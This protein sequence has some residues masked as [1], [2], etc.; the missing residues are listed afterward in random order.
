M[1]RSQKNADTRAAAYLAIVCV[2]VATLEL[3][4]L[5]TLWPLENRLADAFIRLQA[6]SLQPDPDI[7]VVDIDDT[8]LAQME[9]EVGRWPWPRS[10]YGDLVLGIAAQQPRAI[11]FDIL[12]SENDQYRP[13]SD[14]AFN[15]ALVGL[16]NIFFPMVRLKAVMDVQGAP[17]TETAAML[18][19]QRTQGADDKARLALLPPLVIDPAHWRLGIINFEED[20]DGVGRRYSLYDEAY[21]WRIPSLPA[22]V[23]HDLG[24]AVPE[25]RDL[26]L[27]WRGQVGAIRHISFA[28]L[29]TDLQRQQRHRAVDEFK[30]KIVVIGTT[31]TGMYD[32]RVTPLASLYPAIDM[33]VMAIDNL[34]NGR[35][36]HKVHD[37]VVVL[38]SLFLMGLLFY[39]FVRRLHV[40]RMGAALVVASVLLFAAAWLA[41]ERSTLMPVLTPVLLAWLTYIVFS[42]RDYRRERRSREQAVQ[43]FSRFVNP[44]VVQE[45]VAYGGLGRSG[46]SRQITVLFSDI[47]GFTTLSEKRSPVQVVDLLNR[48]FS[49]QVEVVFRHGGSLDKF[50]GDCIMAFWGAPLDDADHAL[51]AVQTALE[52]ADALQNFKRALGAEDADFDVGIG[53]HTGPAVVGLIGSEHRQE[54]T[55]IGDTVNLASR[56]EG[57][58]K[59]VSRIL[60]S[61]ETMLACGNV[62]DFQSF[63]SFKVKGREKDVELFSPL[64]K[65]VA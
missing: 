35:Q 37:D 32:V 48:Y 20:A 30:D 28:D 59:G 11:V 18:G 15:Q 21:G 65:E 10:V 29:Y 42:L 13:D 34:K 62:F 7:V 8:S 55:V 27:A 25:Q 50:I 46:E 26:I 56:I 51:H 2:L 16:D 49:L 54:Y 1:Q 5:H 31:A 44:Q 33:L 4:F 64:R 40:L 43:L 23:A 12:F 57:L 3:L 19:L 17:V 47:R 38:L 36:M 53:I 52:M 45:L 41:L 63:G 6:R 58:T 14:A 60:V 9:A 22:R 61:R 24:Y 39:G